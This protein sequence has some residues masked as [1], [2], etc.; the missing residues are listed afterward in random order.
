MKKFD[1]KELDIAAL[2]HLAKSG[3]AAIL[4][5]YHDKELFKEVFTKSDNS[6]LTLADKAAH[7]VITKGLA[8]LTPGIPI[9]SEEG[10]DIPYQERKDWSYYWCV[11][12]L[13]GTKEFLKRNGEFTVNIA[14]IHNRKPILGVIHVPDSGITYYGGKF[15]GASKIDEK[16]IESAISVDKKD[17]EWTSLGSRSHG[18]DQET[19]ILAKFPIQYSISK[20]SS[21]K[22][23][24]L[25]EGK[26][27]VYLRLG[28]TCEWDTAAGQA[29]LVAAGGSLKTLEGN[30]FLYNKESMLNGSFICLVN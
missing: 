23:C 3:G 12:P 22:F 28:P 2:I 1:I 25:A 6:P 24:L 18:S 29:I 8:V 15:H 21:L 26:A 30:A 16:G 14:L 20:G 9:L 7:E 10:Q 11:D 27:Q 17:T 13:D 4:K 5:V 19:E